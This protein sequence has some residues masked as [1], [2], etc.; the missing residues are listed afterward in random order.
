MTDYT[1]YR[2]DS[3][4]FER[5][6]VCGVCWRVC[7]DMCEE[8]GGPI[9]FDLL[10]SM[11]VADRLCQRLINN[12]WTLRGIEYYYHW[13]EAQ[14]GFSRPAITCAAA[15]VCLS[16]RLMDDAPE[17]LQQMGEDMQGLLWGEGG[18]LYDNMRCAARQQDIYLTASNYGEIPPDPGASPQRNGESGLRLEGQ[19][20]KELRYQLDQLSQEL[21]D[22][23]KQGEQYTIGT[24]N[25][26]Y[27]PVTINNY[28]RS[29]DSL[30]SSEGIDE[31]E[32]AAEKRHFPLLTPQ[33]IREGKVQAVEEELRSAAKG[34][35]AKLIQCIR[36]NEALGYLDTKNMSSQALYDALNAYFGLKYSVRN[37]TKYRH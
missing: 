15:T 11:E 2:P 35:A 30:H 34:S 16:L 13:L 31:V 3:V 25:N 27:A 18:E 8:W 37:F 32:V 36:T 33:C 7:M 29:D 5:N 19:Q 12:T 17:P 10:A 9:Q 20:N 21:R 23:N 4:L 26:Y 14:L 22:M 1:T 6:P 28:E 24:Q